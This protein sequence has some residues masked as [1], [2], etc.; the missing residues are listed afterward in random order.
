MKT[1]RF[2]LAAALLAAAA[3]CSG[4]VTAP[5]SAQP[6]GASADTA[7]TTPTAVPPTDPEPEG[8]G[9][10]MGSGGGK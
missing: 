1:S 7:P 5:E 9:G 8:D 6:A 2:L 3:A 4:S 10:Y